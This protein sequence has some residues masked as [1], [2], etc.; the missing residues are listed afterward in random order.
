MS[1]ADSA[2]EVE[3]FASAWPARLGE[4]A[5]AG[6]EAEDEVFACA[7]PSEVAD[8]APDPVRE[9]DALWEAFDA[10]LGDVLAR[11]RCP[12]CDSFLDVD[13]GETLA[14]CTLCGSTFATLRAGGREGQA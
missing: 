13:L 9:L 7:W 6:A 8:S 14:T 11:G 1:S 12:Y 3:I 10:S 5:A 2:P 4:Q